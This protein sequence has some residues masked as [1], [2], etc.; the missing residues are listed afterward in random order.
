MDEVKEPPLSRRCGECKMHDPQC[1]QH[2]G[3]QVSA[4]TDDK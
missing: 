1:A 4:A 3:C 2:N